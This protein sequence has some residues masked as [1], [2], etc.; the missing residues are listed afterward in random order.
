MSPLPCKGGSH[1]PL[2]P[3][4]KV[5]VFFYRGENEAKMGSMITKDRVYEV[6]IDLGLDPKQSLELTDDGTWV[7]ED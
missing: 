1:N 3:L 6:I 4:E 2:I 5:L 7:P